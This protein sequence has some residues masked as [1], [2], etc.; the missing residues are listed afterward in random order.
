LFSFKGQNISRIQRSLHLLTPTLGQNTLGETQL[1]QR[2]L[3]A[4]YG[5]IICGVLHSSQWFLKGLVL[6]N[7]CVA[8]TKLK[9]ELHG[10]NDVIY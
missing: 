6:L 3:T 8:K 1:Q 5:L 7:F 2:A 9:F 10:N 4:E